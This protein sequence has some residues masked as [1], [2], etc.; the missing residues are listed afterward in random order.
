MSH[1]FSMPVKRKIKTDVVKTHHI[2][3]I[4]WKRATPYMHFRKDKNWREHFEKFQ[5]NTNPLFQ[6]FSAERFIKL[7][8]LWYFFG[9]IYKSIIYIMVRF[10]YK[11]ANKY[12]LKQL[13]ESFNYDTTILAVYVAYL[14]IYFTS[15]EH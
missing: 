5:L 12:L 3:D 9:F 7:S 15:F 11:V 4:F 6:R 10:K 1:V 14:N 13:K 2:K 8:V